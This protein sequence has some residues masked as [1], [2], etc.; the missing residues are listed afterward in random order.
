[1]NDDEDLKLHKLRLCKIIR[2]RYLRQVLEHFKFSKE[3][4]L[5]FERTFPRQRRSNP[6]RKKREAKYLKKQTEELFK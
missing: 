2:S 6:I 5:W 3:D 4:L 1:M